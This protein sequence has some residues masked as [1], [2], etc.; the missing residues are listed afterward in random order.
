M[1]LSLSTMASAAPAATASEVLATQASNTREMC[2]STSDERWGLNTLLAA[3][4]L[5]T[6]F[7][8]STAGL[9]LRQRVIDRRWAC[10]FGLSGTFQLR[11]GL[12]ES[13]RAE[14]QDQGRQVKR[15][16][17]QRTPMEQRIP[18]YVD[19]Q[20]A[21]IVSNGAHDAAK[22]VD[23]QA[24]DEAVE[25]LDTEN[26]K[27]PDAVPAHEEICPARAAPLQWRVFGQRSAW[28][29]API[30]LVGKD[31]A[32]IPGKVS[33]VSRPPGTTSAMAVALLRQRPEPPER[34]L[35]KML[36][37]GDEAHHRQE[38][39]APDEAREVAAELLHHERPRLALQHPLKH[40]GAHDRRDGRERLCDD[41]TQACPVLLPTHVLQDTKSHGV[42]SQNDDGEPFQPHVVPPHHEAAHERHDRQVDLADDYGHRGRDAHPRGHAREC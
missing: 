1:N 17:C 36:R 26:S 42:Q 33:S 12:A 14:R 13:L 35:G 10:H 25:D 3:V 2:S 31:T 9:L 7:F 29:E 23:H 18:K 16:V 15:H 22:P 6:V 37:G 40:Q 4:L 8:F 34:A 11:C 24:R 19:Q 28:Y 21:E 41:G 32:S 39:D 30:D 5:L 20:K 38:D 27:E